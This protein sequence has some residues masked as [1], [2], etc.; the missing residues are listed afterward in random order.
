MGPFACKMFERKGE[1]AC[2]V[3]LVDSCDYQV[4]AGLPPLAPEPPK[5]I[6]GDPVYTWRQRRRMVRKFKQSIQPERH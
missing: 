6:Y 1:C 2:S 3:G 5:P 4:G